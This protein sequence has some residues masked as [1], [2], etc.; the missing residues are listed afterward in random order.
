MLMLKILIVEDDEKLSQLYKIVLT[1]AGYETVLA[2][3]GQE[4]WDILDRKSVV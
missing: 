4:A 2:A 1:K 3:N